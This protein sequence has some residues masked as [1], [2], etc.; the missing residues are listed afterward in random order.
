MRMIDN[1]S[2]GKVKFTS[3][4]IIEWM[5]AVSKGEDC[6]LITWKS[7]PP[8]P[9]EPRTP[10]TPHNEVGNSYLVEQAEENET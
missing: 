5:S 7:S 9:N 10:S 2:Q 6:W 3:L 1:D 8:T 4:S